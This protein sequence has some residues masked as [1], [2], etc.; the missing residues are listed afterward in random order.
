MSMTEMSW[1][2]MESDRPALLYIIYLV[3]SNYACRLNV[4]IS[5]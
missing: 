3:F 1:N 2:S 4:L 5:L